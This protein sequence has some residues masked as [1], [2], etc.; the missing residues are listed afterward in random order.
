MLL[1]SGRATADPGMLASIGGMLAGL[2]KPLDALAYIAKSKTVHGPRPALLGLKEQSIA[3]ANQ[4]YALFKLKRYSE[5]IA[6]LR[7]AVAM[8]PELAEANSTLGAALLCS[9]NASGGIAA[10]RAGAR[11][12]HYKVIVHDATTGFSR[13]TAEEVFDMSAV[14]LRVLA[15]Q[16]VLPSLKYA[17]TPDQLPDLN[18]RYAKLYSDGSAVLSAANAAEEAARARW[19]AGLKRKSKATQDRQNSMVLAALGAYQEPQVAAAQKAEDALYKQIST[20]KLIT[21][22]AEAFRA[23]VPICAPAPSPEA[24]LKAWCIPKAVQTNSQYLPLEN[25]Y[26]TAMRNLWAAEGRVILGVAGAS[27]DPDLQAYLRAYATGIATTDY[28][29]MIDAATPWS[30]SITFL[31]GLCTNTVPP[32]A[33]S[34]ATPAAET[35]KRCSEE[36]AGHNIFKVDLGGASLGVTCDHVEAGIA[37]EGIIGA[38]GKT[39]VGK[40]GSTFIIGARG[41][42]FGNDW[43]SG[44]GVK[45]GPNGVEDVFWR[46][47]PSLSAGVGPVS[48]D[49]NVAQTDISFVGAVD[50]ILTAFGFGGSSPPGG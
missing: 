13:P 44:I 3:L 9:G 16:V 45:V 42:A 38:Y 15:K 39:E 12:Q 35:G 32:E 40:D 20:T 4:G 17:T 5:A 47:G 28:H 19:E 10:L 36:G 37:S 1:A 24:C 41:G 34:D 26:D 23:Q 22:F 49:P 33:N 43:E 31:K 8:S 30:A 18:A 7:S 46:T 50:Y 25:A 21:D 6:P 29:L 27:D 2:G 48:I 11:R 14:S